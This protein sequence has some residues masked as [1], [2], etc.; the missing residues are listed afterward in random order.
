MHTQDQNQSCLQVSAGT[1][2]F[3]T[4]LDYNVSGSFRSLNYVLDKLVERASKLTQQQQQNC[5]QKS[6][7][8]KRKDGCLKSR[9]KVGNSIAL[10][11]GDNKKDRKIAVFIYRMNDRMLSYEVYNAIHSV[12]RVSGDWQVYY[13]NGNET[14]AQTVYLFSSAS[15]IFGFHGA[16]L[17]NAFF[18]KKPSVVVF[19]VSY[20]VEQEGHIWRLNSWEYT[21]SKK[22]IVV[23][24]AL[25]FDAELANKG[26]VMKNAKNVRVDPAHLYNMQQYVRLALVIQAYAWRYPGLS[27]PPSMLNPHENIDRRGSYDNFDSRVKQISPEEQSVAVASSSSSP[28]AD[29]LKLAMFLYPTDTTALPHEVFEA[30]HTV[31]RAD[32]DWRVRYYNSSETIADAH[33]LFSAAR[34]VVGFNGAGFVNAIEIMKALACKKPAV[35]VFEISFSIDDKE[36]RSR[37]NTSSMILMSYVVRS[38][39]ASPQSNQYTSIERADIYNMQQYVQLALSRQQFAIRNSGRANATHS[40]CKHSNLSTNTSE[41]ITIGTA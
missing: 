31:L 37:T 9:A 32:G 1:Y 20:Y 16:G 41:M 19:E 6:I 28:T 27:L 14:I 2:I 35:V 23:P 24:Y 3:R 34:F 4:A 21:Y 5:A 13:Y 17:V 11:N 10:I 15:F 22:M 29:D 36:D 38:K 26:E 40:G 30:I 33:R 25:N 7:T 12:L 39:R 8:G 18:C